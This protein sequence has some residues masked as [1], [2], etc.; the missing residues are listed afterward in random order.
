MV[1]WD[2][3]FDFPCS[4]V[5]VCDSNIDFENIFYRFRSHIKISDSTLSLDIVFQRLRFVL[6]IRNIVFRLY[7]DIYIRGLNL[8]LR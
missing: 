6:I 4:C 5:L 7:Y 8:R 3:A 2:S 1:Y